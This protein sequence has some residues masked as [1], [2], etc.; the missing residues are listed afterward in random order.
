MLGRQKFDLR[1]NRFISRFHFSLALR[2]AGIKRSI[3]DFA[4]ADRYSEAMLKELGFGDSLA[5]DASKFEGAS[6]IWDLNRPINSE[7]KERFGLV[8]DGGT[9]EHVFDVAQAM[10]NVAEMLTRNKAGNSFIGVDSTFSLVD[11]PLGASK[12]RPGMKQVA[13]LSESARLLVFPLDELKRLPT[14]GKGVI[15]MGLDDNER[16]ASAIAVGPDGA[17]YSGAGRAGKPTQLSLDSKTL[18]SFA[19]NRARK[20]H[21]LD[22][23]LKDGKLISN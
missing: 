15:L 11:A 3:K 18:K 1:I 21:Y 4:Q 12:V 5:L 17:T 10:E 22:P 19:G 8:I 7:L 2:A 9:L 20:G 13:C 14:G 23:R 16:L 6:L